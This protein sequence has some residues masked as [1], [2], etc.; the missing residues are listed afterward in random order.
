MIRKLLIIALVFISS[1]TLAQNVTIEAYAPNVVELGEQFRLTYTLTARPTSF[2]PPT[3]ADFDVIAGPSTSSSTSIEMING[4]VTQTQTYTYTYIL[5]ATKEGKFSIDAAEATVNGNKIK[6]NALSIEVVK[7][8]ANARQNNQQST[9]QQASGADLP[10]DELFVTIETNK[11]SAYVGEPIEA[12]IKIYTRVGIAGFEEAKF[13]TFDGFWSQEIATEQ[14]ISFERVNVNGKIYNVGTIR[15]YLLFPQK[16]SKL[17]INPFELVVVYQGRSTRSQSIFDEFFGGV[18]NYRKRLV[19]KPISVNIRQLPDNAPE[20][21]VGAVGAYKIEAT[22]D[23]TKLKTNEAVTV[24]L[25]ITGNGN[26]KLAGAPKVEFPAGFELFDPKESDNINTTANNASGTKTIEYIAIPRSA[27]NF[28]IPPVEFT[29]FDLNKESYVTLRSKAMPIEVLADSSAASGVMITG[30]SKEDVKFIGKDIRFIKTSHSKLR[31]I[32]SFVVTSGIY[33]FIYIILIIA[34]LAFWY[35]YSKHREQMTDLSIV[36]T[37]KANK[38]AQKRLK[39]ASI[40]L[41]QDNAEKFYEEIHRA[42]WGYTADKLSIPIANLNSD[43]VKE[44]L[45]KRGVDNI[46]IEEFIR[47]IDVCEFARFAPNKEHSQM[48]ALYESTYTLISKFEQT[49]GKAKSNLW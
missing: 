39:E 13:P 38:T 11:K 6:S 10:N 35:L 30:Y 36:R 48:D 28:E 49:L 46:D 15:K 40:M 45:S 12:T 18:E 4:K 37:R 2:N 22:T 42:L 3:I 9:K 41:N 21:F 26:L 23:K 44:E 17:E 19:S 47:I 16:S 33:I 1:V 5:E 32:N 24:K 27:G 14:N 25:K 7:A 34:F 20:S 31:P 43:R 8:S 29:Y